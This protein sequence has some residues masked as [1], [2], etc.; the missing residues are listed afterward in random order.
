MIEQVR[1]R[2]D[3]RAER[4]CCRSFGDLFWPVQDKSPAKGGEQPEWVA[5]RNGPARVG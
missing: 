3:R 4:P 5:R 2:E 1:G